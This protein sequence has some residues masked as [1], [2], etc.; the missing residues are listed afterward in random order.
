MIEDV[1]ILQLSV[2]IVVEVYA[3]LFARMDTIA[4]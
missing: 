1:V 2:A 4:P 3:N